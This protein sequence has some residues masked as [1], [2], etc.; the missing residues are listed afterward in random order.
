VCHCGG[1]AMTRLTPSFS[2]TLYV[3]V[4]PYGLNL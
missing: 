2:G 3:N 1:D 4:A